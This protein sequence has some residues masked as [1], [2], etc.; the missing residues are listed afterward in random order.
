[1]D[2]Q[3]VNHRLRR[4]R[5]SPI[6]SAR[7]LSRRCMTCS[8]AVAEAVWL[9]MT[10]VDIVIELGRRGREDFVFNGRRR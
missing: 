8:L 2:V 7:N 5:R 9:L 1:M 4:L 3:V 10:D 6:K